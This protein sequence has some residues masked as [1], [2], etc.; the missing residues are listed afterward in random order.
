L[1]AGEGPD[2]SGK[3]TVMNRLRD[4]LEESGHPALLTNWN[5]TATL[6]NLMMRLNLSGDLTPVMRCVF[7]V[8]ELA[9]RYYYLIAPALKSGKVVLANKYLVSARAHSRI[10]GEDPALV[11]RLY[12]FA[13]EPDLILYFDIEAD[14]AVKR[15]LREGKIGFWEAGLDLAFGE[16]VS[17][18]LRRYVNGDFTDA[19]LA[20]SFV[21]FQRRLR[22]LQLDELRGRTVAHIDASAC[23][24]RVFADALEAIRYLAPGRTTPAD[25]CRGGGGSVP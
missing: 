5:D 24:E 19:C 21:Q 15:K 18:L 25:V 12:D 3:T 10:R 17:E 2:G 6:Y 8:A 4:Y 7:G 20:G 22:D 1:I 11:T 23:P 9:A 13:A 16:P 14:T